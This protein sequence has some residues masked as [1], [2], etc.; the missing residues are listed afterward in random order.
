MAEDAN[1][2]R[3]TD[4]EVTVHDGAWNTCDMVPEDG[5]D[6]GRPVV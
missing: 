6:G 4:C 3:E 5:D 2:N 1:R